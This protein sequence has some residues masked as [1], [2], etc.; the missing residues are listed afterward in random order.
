MAMKKLREETGLFHKFLRQNGLKKTYQKDLILETFLNTEGHLSVE[1][2]YALV[3]KK[4]KRIGVVTVFRTMKT[5]TSCGI[6]REIAL[7]DGPTRFEHSYNHPAHHHIVCV[8]CRKAI[9]YVCPALDKIQDD[10]VRQYHFQ[11]HYHRF[12]TYGICEDCRANRPAFPSPAKQDTEN[13]F[14]MDALKMI[15]FMAELALEFYSACAKGNLDP[16]GKGVF[17]WM[18]GEE[19]RYIADVR[20]RLAELKGSGK[21]MENVPVFLHFDARALETLIPDTPGHEDRGEFELDAKASAALVLKLARE[22]A[23]Y[24][25]LYSAQFSETQGKKI[26]LGFAERQIAHADSVLQLAQ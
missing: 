18:I 4:D 20:Q 1:D 17:E 13:I 25:K 8:E 19:E 26:L 10:I 24:F 22:T 3:K 14:A 12:Q 9:E 23:E 15:L 16:G 2:I 7:G 6:A 11:P 21:V 5:L